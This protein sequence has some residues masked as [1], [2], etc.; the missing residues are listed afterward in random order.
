MAEPAFPLNNMG[1]WVRARIPLADTGFLTLE[2]GGVTT[3]ED[4]Q[5]NQQTK[6]STI[7]NQ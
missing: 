4:N 5:S 1:D 7:A 3:A 2:L 6:K